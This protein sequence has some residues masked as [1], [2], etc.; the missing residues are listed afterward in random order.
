MDANGLHA[1]KPRQSDNLFAIHNI[2]SMSPKAKILIAAPV[3]PEIKERLEKHFEVQSVNSEELPLSQAKLTELLSDKNGALLSGSQMI[4]ADLLAQTPNL[5]ILSNMS[6]GYNNF[7]IAAMQAANV[8]GTNAPGVLT[9]T[10]ADFGFALLLATARRVTES[11]HYLRAGKWKQWQYDT[12]L[13]AEVH[14]TTLGIIGMGRIGQAIARRGVLGFG[15]NLIYHNRSRLAPEVEQTLHAEYAATKEE[16]LEKADHVVLVVPYTPAAH[17]LIGADELALMK[18]TATLINIARGGIVD[19]QALIKVLKDKGIAAAGLDVFENEPAF[20]P[21]FL[22]LENVVLT[23]HIASA[24]R[25]TRLAMAG[26]AADNLI[27]FFEGREVLTP[28]T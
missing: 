27:A 21:E 12:L 19:D 3:F 26:L 16:V 13:G 28:V 4:N 24:T 8:I 17:H 18:P 9:E 14:G 2:Q 23:P 5:Q 7:D 25:P 6:V 22:E 20:A 15:M 10:T 11:E 1:R